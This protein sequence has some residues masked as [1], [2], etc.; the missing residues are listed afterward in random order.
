MRKVR[1]G[2]IGCGDI[3]QKRVAPA[4]RDA[5]RCELYAVARAQADRAQEFAQEFGAHTHY[6]DWRNLIADAEIDAVYIATPVDLHAEQTIAAAQ[7][8]KHVLCEKPMALTVADCDRA[9][10]ACREAG[11]K[12]GIAY[13]RRFYPVLSRIKQIIAS[14]E[15]GQPVMARINAFEQ[16]DPQPGEPRHWLIEKARSGGGPMM[17]FGCHRIEVLMNLLGPIVRMQAFIDQVRLKRDVEDTAG[18]FFRFETGARATLLVSH[19]TFESQ[20][21]LD[22]FGSGGTLRVPVLNEGQLHIETREGRRDE[23]HPPHANLHQPLVEDFVDAVIEDRDP[24]VGAEM[25]REVQRIEE[26]IYTA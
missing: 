15:I 26:L 4:L 23:L 8:G 2:L 22:V 1:W 12:L 7:A 17:D 11:V 14:G 20:D 19:A 6:A 24:A 10:A 13:Y 25:G 3:S 16:F 5:D 9:N 21:T 18:A